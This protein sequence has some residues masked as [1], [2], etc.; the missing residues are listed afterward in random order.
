[1]HELSIA[2]GIVDV[3]TEEA[4]KAGHGKIVKINI[5]MGALSGVELSLFKHAWPV[6]S[7]DTLLEYSELSIEWIKGEALCLDCNQQFVIEEIYDTCPKCESFKKEIVK[8]KEL[9]IKSLEII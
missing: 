6:A 8:G 3:A 4:Q 1:M 2:I 9:N 7:K 5:R